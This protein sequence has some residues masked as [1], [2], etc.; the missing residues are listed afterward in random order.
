[1]ALLLIHMNVLSTRIYQEY[2]HRKI[3]PNPH[4]PRYIH[5]V[6]GVGYKFTD[7]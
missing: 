7:Q 1:M 3:E 5:S 4:E 2:P 6:Y